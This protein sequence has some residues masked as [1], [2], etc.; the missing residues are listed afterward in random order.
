GLLV[1]ATGLIVSRYLSTREPLA[2]L[3]A[4]MIVS[5]AYFILSTRMHERYVFNALMLATPLVFL[6]GRYLYATIAL[7]VT[8]L[9]N[10]MYS[11]EYLRVMSEHVANANS[12][13]LNPWL[14]RPMALLNVA[15]FFYVAYTYLGGVG[16]EVADRFD[17]R[18][19]IARLWAQGRTW[20]APLEG[21][22]RM[23]RPDWIIGSAM[24]FGSFLIMF[25][26]YALPNEKIF[27]EIYYA[28]AGEEYLSGKDIFEYTHPPLTKLLITAS[29][30]LFGGL[31]GAGDTATGW[32]FL[33]VV[34]GALMVLIVYCFAKRLLGSTLFA[35]I[36]AGL[37]AFDGFH[38]VQSRIATPEITVA[39]FSIFTL[40]AFYRFWLASRVRVAPWLGTKLQPLLRAEG[41]A[42]AAAT[43]VSAGASAFF[44]KSDGLATH[45][46]VFLYFELGLYAAVRIFAPRF[47][48]AHTLVSY[49]DGSR[50][51]EGRLETFDG[52]IVPLGKGGAVAGLA[53]R[54]DK[55]ALTYSDDELRIE[56]GRGTAKYITPEGTA[57]FEPAGT[58]TS[59]G[60]TIDGRRDGVIWM[61]ALAVI[62]GC[63]AASKWNGLFDYFVVWALTGV[64]VLQ[65][66]WPRFV[67][68]GYKAVGE[69]FKGAA[70]PA[71]W[72]NPFGISLDILVAGMLFV[73]ATIYLAAYIP[74]LT[75]P[76]TVDGKIVHHSLA[77]LI[78]LQK[79]MYGYHCCEKTV[80][81][82]AGAH[83]PYASS[84]WQWPL[85]DKPISYYYHDFRTGV[86]TQQAEGCCVA[87]IIALPNPI[88]WWL[89]L[90]SVPMLAW[91]A[92]KERNKG[93]AILF[94][95]YMFQWLPWI[96]TP[97][98]AFEYHFFP[99]LAI[100]CLADA[101]LLKRVWDYARD[102][103]E[104][105]WP[106][107]AVGVYLL[108]V[109][110]AFVFWYPILAGTHITWQA[111]DSRMMHW[112]FGNSWV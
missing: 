82:S 108:S 59:G 91:L 16:T 6:R 56:Y 78:A 32:R 77:D 69:A 27:D 93:Y 67:S 62:A 65:S 17:L 111:W 43:L 19:A 99:N 8:L 55:N 90:V 35:G 61:V 46:V 4:A 84:W 25:S 45:V 38:F 48:A 103:S 79:A 88:V 94:T 112:L 86:A 95:A 107:V 21:V 83:H 40:Y 50:V 71:V 105:V 5:L 28:R 64:V 9:A 34:V 76:V 42:L 24:A 41:W 96:G 13:N 75:L 63:L 2:F 12:V 36:A 14:S 51:L 30:T 11:F 98:L 101:V 92:W 22:S 104:V 81:I 31:H 53:T 23:T 102:N 109:V 73:G 20:F 60:E 54:G 80:M 3:E 110:A 37:L 49:A 26:G 74:Y 44:G 100:I 47:R 52:G 85:L 68:A 106:K 10:L 33:N 57:A 58:M 87:E 7:S 66:V 89:G 18:A 39:F 97:R 15:T 72:G 29:M 1:V 70:R